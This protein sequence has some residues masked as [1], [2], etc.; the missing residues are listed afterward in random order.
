MG[1]PHHR[2][3]RLGYSTPPLLTTPPC[4]ILVKCAMHDMPLV[5]PIA[6]QLQPCM[7]LASAD[8]HSLS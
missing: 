5:C 4:E 3:A 6:I 8:V 7:W 2:V 1:R